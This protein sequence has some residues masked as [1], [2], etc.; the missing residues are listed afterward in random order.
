VTDTRDDVIGA[1]GAS[2]ETCAARIEK[3]F[4]ARDPPWRLNG[5]T[6]KIQEIACVK[7]VPFPSGR[8]RLVCRSDLRDAFKANGFDENV[9]RLEDHRANRPPARTRVN[10]RNRSAVAVTKGDDLPELETFDHRGEH[11]KR[12]VVHEANRPRPTHRLGRAIADPAID[13][14]AAAGRG[15]HEVRKVTPH[16]ET[17]QAFVQE[18]DR[19][20][21]VG[22]RSN[23]AVFKVLSED[24]KPRQRGVRPALHDEQRR[25]R[26]FRW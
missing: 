13:E 19:W 6:N 17:A 3:A 8:H 26:A 14:R 2:A 1:V 7:R 4:Q 5:S 12:F 25:R 23:P 9:R 22:S 15:R 18:H 10:D 16:P 21:V 20:R 11:L 24:F